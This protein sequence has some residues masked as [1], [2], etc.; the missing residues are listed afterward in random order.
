MH[1]TVKYKLSVLPDEAISDLVKVDDN[2]VLACCV[3]GVYVILNRNET[4]VFQEVWRFKGLS[5]PPKG[6]QPCGGEDGHKVV[7]IEKD[8]LAMID[9]KRKCLTKCTKTDFQHVLSKLNGLQSFSMLKPK[10]VQVEHK[11]M[12]IKGNTVTLTVFNRE[13]EGKRDFVIYG[14]VIPIIVQLHLE[15]DF[16]K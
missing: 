5:K 6:L 7:V 16:I 8:G 15:N 11:E 10:P 9:F 13:N 2:Q 3:S 14:P 12:K 4:S 1:M